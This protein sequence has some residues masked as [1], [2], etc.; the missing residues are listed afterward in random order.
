MEKVLPDE[1]DWYRMNMALH[2]DAPQEAVDA[3]RRCGAEEFEV[4]ATRLWP[5][6]FDG[7]LVEIFT[8]HLQHFDKTPSAPKADNHCESLGFDVV[9]VSTAEFVG[10][11][12]SCDYLPFNCAPLS[13]NGMAT[14]HAVNRWCLLENFDQAVSAAQA[15]AKDEPEPGPYVIV[16][17]LRC[18]TRAST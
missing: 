2:Y 6:I 10:P 9:S 16:E 4:H 17:V 15:F 5:M 8:L 13:C 14:E 7:A 11:E 12:K 1:P 3:A 18:A